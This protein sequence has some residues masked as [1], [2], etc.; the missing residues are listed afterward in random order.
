MADFT[1]TDFEFIFWPI[2]VPWC[3]L[4]F[5]LLISCQIFVHRLQKV[6]FCITFAMIGMSDKRAETQ[7]RSPEIQDVASSFHWLWHLG[8]CFLIPLDITD[9][10]GSHV[11]QIMREKYYGTR[12]EWSLQ[13]HVL[14]GHS[15]LTYL[16]LTTAW[17]VGMLIKV[18]WRKQGHGKVA[19]CLWGYRPGSG[20]SR[21]L[22]VHCGSRACPVDQH[23]LLWLRSGHPRGSPLDSQGLLCSTCSHIPPQA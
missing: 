6:I 22:T 15:T 5:K 13:R 3:H 9:T 1:K 16:L 23:G 17:E 18:S 10:W 11:P 4:D 7:T 21:G 19:A 2:A 8:A 12:S 14:S 20:R